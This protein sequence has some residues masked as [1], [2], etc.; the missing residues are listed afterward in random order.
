MSAAE[1]LEV[2]ASSGRT[3][4]SRRHLRVAEPA[5]DL[6]RLSSRLNRLERELRDTWTAML[7]LDSATAGRI[8]HAGKLVHRAAVVL[9]D[10]S[11]IY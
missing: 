5:A 3:R 7:E 6:P 2:P 10:R 9:D 11:T 4:K 8:G 1:P